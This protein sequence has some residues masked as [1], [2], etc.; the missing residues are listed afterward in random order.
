MS[1]DES[2]YQELEAAII[3]LAGLIWTLMTLPFTILAKLGGR[4]NPDEPDE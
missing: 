4:Q 3:A 2:E 1:K